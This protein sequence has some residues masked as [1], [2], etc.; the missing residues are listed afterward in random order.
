VVVQPRHELDP[1]L[2]VAA[3]ML[4]IVIVVLLFERSR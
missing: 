4:V 3:V 1:A 2:T